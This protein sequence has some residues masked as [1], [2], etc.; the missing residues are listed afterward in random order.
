MKKLNENEL[1]EIYGGA[2][3]LKFLKNGAYGIIAGCVLIASVIY[4]Y[5]HPTACNK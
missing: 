2:S 1:L 3:F 5:I 4:G